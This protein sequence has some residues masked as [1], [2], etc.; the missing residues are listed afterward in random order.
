MKRRRGYD[1]GEVMARAM[2]RRLGVPAR[3][4]LRRG[5]RRTQAGAGRSERL[6]GPDLIGIGR[7]CPTS[8]VIIDDVCTTGASLSAATRLLRA[9]GAVEVRASVVAVT[10]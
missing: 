9:R 6:R 8:V 2:A 7:G 1:Q 3:P 10:R 4:M 5:S